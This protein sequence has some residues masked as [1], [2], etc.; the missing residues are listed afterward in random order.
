[1]T[2]KSQITFPGT[3]R[4]NAPADM[5]CALG[6]NDQ[7]IYVVPSQNLVIVR[8]GNTAGGF[9]LAASAF[10]NTLWD[11]INKL[12]CALT[13]VSSYPLEDSFRLYPNPVN[14]N[15]TIENEGASISKIG[16]FDVL[17][18]KILTIEGTGKA[19]K[20]EINFSQFNK[21]IYFVQIEGANGA[22]VRKKVIKY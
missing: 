14:N 4:S 7:K 12:N 15:L 11:Y 9:N 3:L 22:I 18:N 21:G 17:G 1:M 8:Q 16:V 19:K 6:K 10:D 20:T 5:Y 13:D 2:Q